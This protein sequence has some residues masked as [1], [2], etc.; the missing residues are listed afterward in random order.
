M[1]VR[2]ASPS[3]L[4]YPGIIFISTHRGYASAQIWGRR[5]QN[6]AST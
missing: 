2:W 5:W 1:D 4:M 3:L 6:A